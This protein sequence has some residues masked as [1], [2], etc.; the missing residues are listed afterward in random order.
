MTKRLGRS[1][2]KHITHHAPLAVLGDVVQ[3][4]DFCAP[5]RE[6]VKLGCKSVIPDP[7]EK[8][9]AVVVRMLADCAAVNQITTRLRPG[10]AARLMA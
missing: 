7:R 3:Q 9:R 10:T 2:M 4:R 1:A 5:L 8:L 6:H